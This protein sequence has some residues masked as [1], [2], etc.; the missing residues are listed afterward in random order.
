MAPDKKTVLP[1]KKTVRFAFNN[2]L[3]KF[4]KEI[5]DIYPENTEILKA[6][7][8]LD[9]MFRFNPMDKNDLIIK[10]WLVKVY[11]PYQDVIDATHPDITFFFEKDYSQDVESMSN[12]G[13]IMNL[14]DKIREPIRG[15]SDTSKDICMDYIK[16]LSK[17]SDGYSHM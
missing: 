17:F 10:L 6:K 14:I 5:C 4:L 13:E 1:D 12:A 8:S 11:L 15:M 3:T 9:T 16:K 2:L 7:R